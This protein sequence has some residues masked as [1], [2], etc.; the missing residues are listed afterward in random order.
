MY[1][2]IGCEM[3][4]PSMLAGRARN[5]AGRGREVRGPDQTRECGRDPAGIP[6]WDTVVGD[7]LVTTRAETEE[8]EEC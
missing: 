7:V 4:E 2:L 3:V 1:R 8:E 6:P 5:V